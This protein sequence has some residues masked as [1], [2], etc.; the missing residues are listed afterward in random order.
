MRGD[1]SRQGC[2]LGQPGLAPWLTVDIRFRQRFHCC[3]AWLPEFKTYQNS[4]R[5]KCDIGM[6]TRHHHLRGDT[7]I[8]T[9]TWRAN[10][11]RQAKPRTTAILANCDNASHAT[12]NCHTNDLQPRSAGFANDQLE[13]TSCSL[14][15]HFRTKGHARVDTAHVR[16][17][18]TALRCTRLS[19]S[20]MYRSS[21]YLHPVRHLML[22]PQSLQPSYLR[23][24]AVKRDQ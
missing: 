11:P 19:S 3:R 14:H 17:F 18:R 12:A 4:L 2:P 23:I 1:G 16:E 20:W 15:F 13:G 10:T 24:H 8:A 5:V 21:Q 22:Q 7:D 9:Q 6:E